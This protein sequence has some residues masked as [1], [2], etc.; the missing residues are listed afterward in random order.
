MIITQLVYFGANLAWMFLKYKLFQV[1]PGNLPV[2]N[3]VAIM[4]QC[5]RARR[6]KRKGG[7]ADLGRA[8]HRAE[9]EAAKST[10]VADA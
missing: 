10:R 6:V 2:A 9:M 8:A 7:M 3:T 4:W 5:D 1:A